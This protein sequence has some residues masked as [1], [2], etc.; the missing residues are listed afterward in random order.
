MRPMA[1]VAAAVSWSGPAGPS[2]TTTTRP[3]AR[4]LTGRDGGR[5]RWPSVGRGRWAGLGTVV[6][7]LLWGGTTPGEFP[8]LRNDPYLGLTSIFEPWTASSSTDSTLSWPDSVTWRRAWA[9]TCS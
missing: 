5:V 4:P 6:G 2:P 3:I 7:A 8:V 1:E 9:A